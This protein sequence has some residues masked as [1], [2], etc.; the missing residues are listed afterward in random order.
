MGK[1]IDDERAQAIGLDFVTAIVLFMIALGFVYSSLPGI[2]TSYTG[3]STKMYPI[4]DRM[5]EVMVKDSSIGF[6]YSINMSEGSSIHNVLNATKVNETFV[7]N[8]IGPARVN[9]TWWEFGDGVTNETT[10]TT[11]YENIT[12]SLVGRYDCYMQIRPTVFNDTGVDMADDHVDGN[13]STSGDLVMIE[14]IVIMENDYY[15]LMIWVWG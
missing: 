12:E 1:I 13:V 6:A 7:F 14:R 11:S 5:S 9:E 4:V 8:S 15:K 10:S 2:A 3:E